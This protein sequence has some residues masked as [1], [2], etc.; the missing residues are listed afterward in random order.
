MGYAKKALDL[1]IRAN[2]V[3]EFVNEMERFIENTKKNMHNQDE[4]INP[5]D[6]GDPL[7]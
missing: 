6:I 1:A 3:D 4:N 7:M 2:N 5:M